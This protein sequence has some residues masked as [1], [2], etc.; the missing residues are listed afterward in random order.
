MLRSRSPFRQLVALL[1]FPW[2]LSAVLAGDEVSWTHARTFFERKEIVVRLALAATQEPISA[3]RARELLRYWRKTPLEGDDPL[4]AELER[5][6]PRSREL[7]QTLIDRWGPNDFTLRAFFVRNILQDPRIQHLDKTSDIRRLLHEN[8]QPSYLDQE[9]TFEI[10]PHRSGLGPKN[11]A[12]MEW[13]NL[14][15]FVER[16]DT[17]VETLKL[18]GRPVTKSQVKEYLFTLGPQDPQLRA[19]FLESVILHPAVQFRESPLDGKVG[20]PILNTPLGAAL[21]LYE[22]LEN[23]EP[24]S[25]IKGLIDDREYITRQMLHQGSLGEAPPMDSER[26]KSDPSMNQRRLRELY[27][28]TIADLVLDPARHLHFA[29]RTSSPIF[30]LIP[31]SYALIE[32]CSRQIEALRSA[33]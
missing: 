10:Q 32:F 24:T 28:P 12:V 20:P 8:W 5:K 19:E 4:A 25:R 1:A 16:V 23:R 18:G 22:D 2:A 21:S 15:D 30:G 7:L 27:S 11:K 31:G 33:K 13:N 26:L 6:S 29:R 14:R 9:A 3:D 17:C